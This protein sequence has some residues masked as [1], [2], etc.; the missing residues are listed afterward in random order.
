MKASLVICLLFCFYSCKK[1]DSGDPTPG[2]PDED[3]YYH[4]LAT[5]REVD[6]QCEERPVLL[7]MNDLLYVSHFSLSHEFTH[8]N[9]F[10]SFAVPDSLKARG[11]VV[12][13]MFKPIYKKYW[14]SCNSFSGPNQIEFSSIGPKWDLGTIEIVEIN[15]ECG[16]RVL[17]KVNPYSV[18]PHFYDRAWVVNLPDSLKVMGKRIDCYSRI[19]SVNEAIK[20]NYGSAF[21]QIVVRNLHP[22]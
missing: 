7:T 14:Q 22:R 5:V 18:A 16:G 15:P 2:Q 13:L 20:C 6:F 9:E 19:A 12:E 11:Q 1:W 4:A 3:F 21:R 8:Q 17:A 10:W